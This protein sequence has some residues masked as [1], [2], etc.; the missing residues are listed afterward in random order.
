MA[1]AKAQ[2]EAAQPKNTDELTP[3]QAKAMAEIEARRQQAGIAPE[4]ANVQP[5]TTEAKPE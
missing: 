1:R 3:E 2:R 5:A 4:P